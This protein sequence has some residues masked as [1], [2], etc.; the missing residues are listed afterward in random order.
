MSVF[1]DGGTSKSATQAASTRYQRVISGVVDGTEVIP[2]GAWVSEISVQASTLSDA[3]VDVTPDGRAAWDTLTIKAG[4]S[5]TIAIDT[6]DHLEG[7]EIVF[8]GIDSYAI[9]I[10]EAA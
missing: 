2:A 7:A 1:G 10:S 5:Y 4:T 6:K 3:T 9:V 8:V